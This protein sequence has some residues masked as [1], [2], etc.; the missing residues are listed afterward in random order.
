MDLLVPRLRDLPVL[1]IVTHRPEYTPPWTDHAHVTALG[2]NR[3][4]RRQAAELITGLAKGNMLPLD[5][6]DRIVA[7]TDGVPLFMEELTKSVLESTVLT[8]INEKSL[9]GAPLPPL[10]IP[11]TLRDSLLARLDRLAPIREIA[12]IGAC[13]GREFS[14]E[15][16]AAI[17][18]LERDQLDDALDQLTKS[19]LVFRR[20]SPPESI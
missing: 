10:A 6:L 14:Y 15:L 8:Q 11:T 16:M 18:P 7:H 13:I 4:G 20:G 12:Q 1:M 3:L 19:G 2:L 17:V 9:I 5:V